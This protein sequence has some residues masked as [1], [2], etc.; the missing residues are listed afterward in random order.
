MARPKKK[1]NIAARTVA[2]ADI[3]YTGADP[4]APVYL[5]KRLSQAF[6]DLTAK[7]Q[8][9]LECC[10]LQRTRS[11]NARKANPDDF[12][13]SKADWAKGTKEHPRPNSYELYAA[14][15]NERF[16][17]DMAALIEHGFV[18]CIEDGYNTRSKSTYRLIGEWVNW[19]TARFYADTHG[20]IP[21]KYMTTF[22][23][24]EQVE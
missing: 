22:M 17:K 20:Q 11:F 2:V 9:L 5:S 12:T 21:P 7:Q 1:T 14:T 3:Q 19:N 6:K 23:H 18:I 16:S 8:I 10:E 4:F 15:S 24:R 13:L